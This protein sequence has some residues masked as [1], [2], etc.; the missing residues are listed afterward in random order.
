M[1]KAFHCIVRTL[2]QCLLV[3]RT[4][5]EKLCSFTLK[6]LVGCFEFL[7]FVH[8]SMVGTQLL[9]QSKE[10]VSKVWNIK[11]AHKSANEIYVILIVNG[12]MCMFVE[13]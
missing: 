8:H 3:Q 4:F 1:K 13:A 12:D 7:H 11:Y 2:L 6:L 9:L 5:F 10:S